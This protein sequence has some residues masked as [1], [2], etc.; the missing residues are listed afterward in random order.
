MEY[1]GKKK[2]DI[3]EMPEEGILIGFK[4]HTR[5]MRAPF[6]I[7]ADFECFTEKMDTCQ[8]YS[9]RAYTKAYQLHRPS[10]FCY[11]VKYVHSDYRDS[12]V[13]FG[14]DAA[15]LLVKCM[16]K[17]VRES[18]KIYGK[19]LTMWMTDTNKESFTASTHSHFQ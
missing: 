18:G 16:E 3:I 19:K 12:I 13:D 6:T 9:S 4:S 14:E 11:R 10:G 15:K 2:A 7:Y 17:E 1:C 8:P 5:Q